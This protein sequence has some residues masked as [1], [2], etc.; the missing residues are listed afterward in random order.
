MARKSDFVMRPGHRVLTGDVP[1]YAIFYG[2]GYS[3]TQKS[4]ILHFLNH[5][6]YTSYWAMLKKAYVYTMATPSQVPGS[7]YVGNTIDVACNPSATW[8]GQYPCKISQ[9]QEQGILDA[10]FNQGLIP[11][12][13]N[14]VYALFLGSN[15]E[16]R[17]VQG[18]LAN[19]NT[20]LG[21]NN[22]DTKFGKLIL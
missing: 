7:P 16:Y 11:R 21:K 12:N 14:A 19:Y 1:V 18:V 13:L 17:F 4:T 20:L 9:W 3:T 22:P 5:V 10:M 8:L 6:R 2:T 15:V